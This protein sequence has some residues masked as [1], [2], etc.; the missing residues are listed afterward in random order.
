MLCTTKIKAY[1]FLE[2]LELKDKIQLKVFSK[3]ASYVH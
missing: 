2:H 3:L 1:K